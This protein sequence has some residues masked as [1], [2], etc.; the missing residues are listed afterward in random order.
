[1][2]SAPE[3]VGSLTADLRRLYGHLSGRRRVQLLLILALMLVS[4][5]AELATLG[6]V[7]PFL[8]L[9]ADPQKAASY[10]LLQSLFGALGWNDPGRILLPATALFAAIALSAGVIRVFLVWASQKFV[11]RV[12]HDL[13]VEVYDRT[14][15]QSYTYHVSKNT[16]EL[17]AGM[18]KIQM[19]IMGVLLPLMHASIAAVMS[20]F[21]LGALL[22]IDAMIALLAAGGFGLL[23]LVVT[24][25]TRRRLRTNSTI[26]SDTQTRRVQAVQEG[27]GGIR[28]VIIDE[29]QAV[30]VEK[31]QRIDL[32]LRDAMAFNVFAATAPR[33]A[34][35]ACG[36]VLIAG[37]AL[38]MSSGPGGLIAALPVL[39]ALALGAQRLLP[40]IQLIYN[41][42][43]QFAGNRQLL[44]DVL[45]ILQLPIP[46]RYGLAGDAAQVPFE[47]E[48]VLDDV[49]FG[50]EQAGRPVVAGLS[51]AIARG[52]RIGLKGKT[53]TGKSTVTDLIMGLL[54]PGE[55]EIR[56]D[57]K[58]LS[59]ET[60]RGWQ[61]QV[62]HV[63]QA[64]YLADTSIA[65]NIA[66]GVPA[67]RIDPERLRDAAR[68][69]ELTAFVDSLAQ[70][71]DTVVGERGIRLS[72]G[73]RQRIGIARALYKRASLLVF[74]EATSAL[75]TETEQAVME[76]IRSLGRDLTMV[77]I[78][79]R[80][81]TL[82]MCD[83]VYRIEDG[84]LFEERATKPR[85]G[86]AKRKATVEP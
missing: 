16:S 57:G 34:I 44:V 43:A 86:T 7:L 9:I 23:Y 5:V 11:L 71:F 40:S 32:A 36:M 78:A 21:I 1:M 29:A 48:I 69:A 13:S 67:E 84:Q 19:V 28:D 80:L 47:R 59:A 22:A 41:S 56:I 49:G 26:I 75:D 45:H 46:A 12:G 17:I 74:D 51:L 68:Q 58:P 38:Y 77:L 79:H 18:N 20:V 35:E 4:A 81:S 73:Q 55:G 70:G 62:A 27:L 60:V 8:A 82:E 65:E 83:R 24:Y 63:P 61:A 42:W 72:G 14:L 85:R 3:T 64:I 30:Y 15:H 31:Y 6:M 54:E 2:T 52:E 50:Y 25:A 76:A 39:G 10:P 33:Y 53:G 66:L 37:L